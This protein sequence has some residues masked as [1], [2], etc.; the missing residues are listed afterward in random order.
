MTIAISSISEDDCNVV[1]FKGINVMD[2]QALTIE[3]TH[4][5]T[6]VE[7]AYGTYSYSI[8]ISD[9]TNVSKYAFSVE[10][11]SPPEDEEGITIVNSFL[12]EEGHWKNYPYDYLKTVSNYFVY[13]LQGGY[14]DN[15]T[16]E[17]QYNTISKLWEDLGSS[18]PHTVSQNGKLVTLD[19]PDFENLGKFTDPYYVPPLV[20]EIQNME[21]TGSRGPIKFPTNSTYGDAIYTYSY[22][23]EAPDHSWG[24]DWANDKW[25]DVGDHDPFRLEVTFENGDRII[26]GHRSDP[27]QYGDD[28]KTIR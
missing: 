27:S 6:F 14:G 9:N 15:E 5:F 18:Y 10:F 22:P 26:T 11:V 4:T 1:L 21:G 2:S 24:Y 17:I 8:E 19:S 16:F 20:N 13:R 25:V 23:G 3:R 7:S 12:I 28:E